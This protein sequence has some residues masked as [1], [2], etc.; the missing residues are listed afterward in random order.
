MS[1]VPTDELRELY[2]EQ[3]AQLLARLELEQVPPADRHLSPHIYRTASGVTFEGK[4]R[5]MSHLPR[6]PR[7][8]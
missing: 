5:G 6:E 1:S 3:Q 2:E 4:F 7:E 8:R